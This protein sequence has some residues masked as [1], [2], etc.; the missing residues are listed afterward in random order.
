MDD[1]WAEYQK[2]VLGDLKRLS[3]D[4]D[5]IED[6]IVSIHIDLAQLK[7]RAGIWG[8]TGG[9]FSVATMIAIEFFLKK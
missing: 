5:R 1:N 9:L 8:L 3:R 4:L 2:M 6:K 7:V